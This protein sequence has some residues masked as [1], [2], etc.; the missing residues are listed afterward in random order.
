MQGK[1]IIK[2]FLIL[3]AAVCL[4]QYLFILPTRGVEKAADAYAAKVAAKATGDEKVTVER[5]A[6]T[7]YLDSMSSEVV[8]K[9]PLLKEYTYEDLKKQQLALGLDLKGGMSVI[10]Q[11]DLKDFLKSLGND[12]KDPIFL[13]ALDNAESIQRKTPGDFVSIFASEYQKAGG[14]SLASIFGRNESLKDRINFSSPNNVVTAL[15]RERANETVDLTFKR[16]KDR[17]DKFGV[18]QPNVSLDATRDLIVVELPGIDNPERAR[19]FLQASAKLEFWDVYRTSDNGISQAMQGA[20]AKLEALLK[21][22]VSPEKKDTSATASADTTQNALLASVDTTANKLKSGK[23][24]LFSVFT[25]NLATGQNQMTAAPS[26]LGFAEK[27]KKDLI[28]SY[29]NRPEIKVLFPADVDFRWSAK[30]TKDNTTGKYTK[31][32]ELYAI[33]KTKG[34]KAPLE[35]DHVTDASANPDS[36]TGAVAVSLKMDGRGA[37]IWGDMTTKA[38]QGGNREIAIVLDD[39]V[40]SAP[41]VQN[42]ILTGDS[43]ITGDFSIQDGKDLANIL[44]IGKL[45]AKTKI[46]QE[47]L[48]GPSLGAENIGKSLK[49]ILIGFLMIMVFMALYYSTGG[50][51]S[52][53]ALLANL[54]FIIGA[55]SNFGTVLT[56]PGIAGLVLT[57]GIAV[58]INV[59]IYERIREELRMGKTLVHSVK[60]GFKHSY[61]AV[62]DA[63]VTTLL[64]SM[65]MAYFGLGPIKGFAVVLIIGIL[66]SMIT[67][68]LITRFLID[69]LIKRGTDV[70]F[71]TPPTKDALTNIHID[72]VGMRKITYAISIGFIIIGIVSYFARGFELGV[73]FKGGYSYNVSFDK[74]SKVNIDDLRNNL[75]TAFEGAVPVVKQV[76]V[77]NTFNITSSYLIDASGEGVDEK[78]VQKLYEGVKKTSGG[79]FSLEQFKSTDFT[80]TKIVSSSKVGATVADD[81]SRSSFKAAF[82]A[83]LL[84]FLY[85]LF[86]F[87]KW[88]YSMG[89]I[90]ALFHDSLFVLG[91]FSLFHGILPFSLEVDQAFIAALLTIIGYSNN[92]TVIVFDRMR[93]FLHI[94]KDK[95]EREII[96]MAIN[97][98]LSRTIITSLLTM[99][100]VLI[101][102]LFGG[103]S[104]KGF[105]FALVVGIIVGT[106][107]SIFIAAPVVY[108]LAK[109]LKTESKA[110]KKHFSRAVK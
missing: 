110:E 82:F 38:A 79:D 47:S 107:S 65:V 84:I 24:P 73:D 61:S 74:N 33:K 86:R 46:I 10:L 99:M 35:G 71:W 50:I 7:A 42:A 15:L 49:S 12:S 92:D 83:L 62:I 14:T 60:E 29:L 20:D 55:L 89:A 76:D 30:P 31:N 58:D 26:V 105:A 69:W 80:G 70:K 101:L 52:I 51:V 21:N 34:E 1:G 2:F 91:V 72:W 16:L 97:S 63:N 77:A 43:Q 104:I 27:N 44:Q 66:F 32:Y 19:R 102:F 87:S 3:L 88:Q 25:P 23:G 11:V 75:T 81:I 109:S 68:I 37:K 85:I 98:T 94:H 59:V 108:D 56:L 6:R 40:V 78:V 100:V 45:P 53:I 90:A 57:M 17:I 5:Q 67:A 64:S 36:R 103:S 106:Y 22:P 28:L 18:T 93:E 13:K 9:I 95:S 41:R 96:N 54:I 39:E 48:V 8:T 4:M